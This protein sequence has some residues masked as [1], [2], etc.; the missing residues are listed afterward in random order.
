MAIALDWDDESRTTFLQQFVGSWTWQE[1]Y[2]VWEQTDQI[3]ADV[4]YEVDFILDFTE[5]SILPE[6]FFSNLRVM[7]N[8]NAATR[9]GVRVVVG[10]S[11]MLERFWEVFQRAYP[12][13]ASTFNIQMAGS[14]EEARAQ[15]AAYRAAHP[16]EVDPADSD[17]QVDE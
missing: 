14:L 7:G 15:I 1:L 11:S 10:S 16:R 8:L 4:P 13:A 12:K 5:G 6:Y 3:M 2:D 9:V 17:G